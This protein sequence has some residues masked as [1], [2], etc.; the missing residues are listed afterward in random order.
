MAVAA[1]ADSVVVT[2]AVAAAAVLAAAVVAAA[3]DVANRAGS[4]FLATGVRPKSGERH[5]N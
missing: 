1:A 2:G 4:N 3:A 5:N